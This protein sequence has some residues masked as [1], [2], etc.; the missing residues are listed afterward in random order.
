MA[1]GELDLVRR[2]LGNQ[3]ASRVEAKFRGMTEHEMR[4]WLFPGAAGIM[5][6]G[7]REMARAAERIQVIKDPQHGR[8]GAKT[9]SGD[10]CYCRPE[11]GKKRCKLHGGRSTGPKTPEGMARTLTALRAGYQRWRAR[12]SRNPDQITTEP[13]I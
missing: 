13:N 7:M 1:D 3:I 11:P 6:S 10:S 2:E 5:L 12:Q 9:R 4:T 8:C